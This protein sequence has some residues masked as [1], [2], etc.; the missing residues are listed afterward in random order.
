MAALLY[1]HVCREQAVEAL[2][3]LTDEA[4]QRFA[5]G[6]PTAFNLDM[7]ERLEYDNFE[8]MQICS[9]RIASDWNRLAQTWSVIDVV[10][11]SASEG[12]TMTQREVWYRL[13]PLGFFEKPQD[14]FDRILDVCAVVSLHCGMP[15]PRESLGVVAA[16][17][18]SMT[19]SFSLVTDEGL[20]SMEGH[21]HSIPGSPE[22]CMS[23]RFAESRA[24]FIV[25]VEKDTV[26]SRL[27]D[28]GFVQL[29]PSIL[30]TARGFPD[31]ATRALVQHAVESLRLPCV[32]V[33]D[34][35]PHGMA[36]M[37][38]YKY[39]SDNFCLE[40][41]CH[42]RGCGAGVMAA[43]WR[44]CQLAGGSRFMCVRVWRAHI[45]SLP[46]LWASLQCSLF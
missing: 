30:I 16:S 21:V 44:V 32:V 11:E 23:M 1:D 5:Q 34:Y 9:C 35:N 3:E 41:Y 36:L 39:G 10:H 38:C 25:V 20:V 2:E 42:R 37:L 43:M 13:K 8:D 19:G 22:E 12:K 31:L 4:Y 17:R 14:V 28:D 18:G 24:R 40:R 26:F 7:V 33:T 46:L 15:C 29:L 6:D 27:V 45:C